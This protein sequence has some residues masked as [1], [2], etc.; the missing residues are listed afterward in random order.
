MTPPLTGRAQDLERDHPEWKPWLGVLEEVV[1]ES[2][3]PQ[4]DKVVPAAPDRQE[5]KI[6]GLAGATLELQPSLVR[7][8][9]ERLMRAAVRSGTPQMATLDRATDNGIDL[10]HL[11]KAAL[12]QDLE[13]LQ[14][15]A[16]H[17]EVDPEAFKA[18]AVLLPTPLLH[19]CHRAWRASIERSWVEGYCP[20]CGGWPAF[21]EVCGIERSRYLRCGRCGGGWEAHCLFCPYCGMAD[22]EELAS[23]VPEKSGSTGGIQVCK[24]CLGYVKSFTL[25]QGTSPDKV[26]FDDLASVELDVAALEA[27]YKKAAG[28]GYA[29]DIT[30]VGALGRTNKFFPWRS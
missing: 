5:S 12:C 20:V 11:L 30:V 21:A 17:L 9:T 25:L 7:R 26:I 10:F 19:A 24:R 8:W 15:I 3:D 18:V 23:L 16:H 4:W 6:P 22:H 28:L 14:Q 29:L 13:P 27:G 2:A 1:R